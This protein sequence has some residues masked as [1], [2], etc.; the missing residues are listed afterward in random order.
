MYGQTS[1]NHAPQMKN[2]RTIITNSR[3]RTDDFIWLLPT[4][5]G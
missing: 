4:S 1:G 5:D 2:S 3:L